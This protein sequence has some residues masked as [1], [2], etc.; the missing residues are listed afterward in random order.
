M[1]TKEIKKKNNMKKKCIT[2]NKN[3]KFNINISNYFSLLLN[4]QLIK[5]CVE[6]S[7]D[8]QLIFFYLKFNENIQLKEN[9]IL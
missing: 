5:F 3:N 9:E 1:S 4:V 2:Q 6:L 7:I 8:I